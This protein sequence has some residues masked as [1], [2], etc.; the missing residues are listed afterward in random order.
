MHFGKRLSLFEAP[1]GVVVLN[2]KGLKKL[3][4]SAE[5][6]KFPGALISEINGIRQTV[7]LA[8]K[9]FELKL[10]K[11]QRQL[12]LQDRI[13]SPEQIRYLR[14]KLK[15]HDLPD[16]TDEAMIDG[17]ANKNALEKETEEIANFRKEFDAFFDY[18]DI[19]ACGIRKITKKFKKRSVSD[20]GEVPCF[21]P[22]SQISAI[23]QIT[24]GL[25]KLSNLSAPLPPGA[26]LSALLVA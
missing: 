10:A 25:C 26:E 16:L 8:I 20:C 18:L 22:A 5:F 11:I 2:Y 12:V 19:T 21:L 24:T 4:K 6:A 15:L 23:F 9:S 13:F 1:P 3:I 7:L 17:L 14:E